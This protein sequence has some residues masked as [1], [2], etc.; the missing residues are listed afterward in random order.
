MGYIIA[1]SK[2]DQLYT[3]ERLKRQARSIALQAARATPTLA[4]QLK[5]LAESMEAEASQLENT[6]VG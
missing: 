4:A 1:G 6:A 2:S 3:I 5:S